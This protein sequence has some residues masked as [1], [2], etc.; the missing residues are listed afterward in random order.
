MLGQLLCP[1]ISSVSSAFI[2]GF[3]GH[4]PKGVSPAPGIPPS[5]RRLVFNGKIVRE[6]IGWPDK[7]RDSS[8]D[9]KKDV[10]WKETV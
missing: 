9:L 1:A 3:P 7:I 4:H 6:I 5:P 2:R 8:Q 10:F